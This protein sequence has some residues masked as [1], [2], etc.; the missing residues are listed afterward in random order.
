[1]TTQT[2]QSGST[3][4]ALEDDVDVFVEATFIESGSQLQMA[5]IGSEPVLLIQ[6]EYDEDERALKFVLTAVDLDPEGLVEVLELILDTARTMAEGQSNDRHEI[7]HDHA[8]DFT[9]SELQV[10]PTLGAAPDES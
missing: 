6:P 1:M 10:A 4:D 7:I 3:F 2:V 9:P 5:L 8:D